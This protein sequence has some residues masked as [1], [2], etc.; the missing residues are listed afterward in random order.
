MKTVT[1]SIGALSPRL[2]S[3]LADQG[4]RM[5]RQDLTHAQRDID[6]M[7]RLAVRGLLTGGERAKLHE[8]L[9]KAIAAKCEPCHEKSKG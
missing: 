9:V 6:A 2:G 8:R 4:L 5:S 3:Q 7:V 1:V